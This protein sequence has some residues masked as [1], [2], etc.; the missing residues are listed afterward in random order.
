MN[1]RTGLEITH[2]QLAALLESHAQWL[3]GEPGGSRLD[4]VGANLPNANF[5]SANLAEADLRDAN[6]ANANFSNAYLAG[7]R[8]GGANLAGVDLTGYLANASLVGACLAD[9]NLVNVNLVEANLMYADLAGADLENA[10]LTNASIWCAYLADANLTGANLAGA[11]LGGAILAGTNL[12]GATSANVEGALGLNIT[13][14]AP[15]RRVKTQAER[16]AQFR[17]RNPEVPFVENLDRKILEAIE[18]PAAFGT[19][20]VPDWHNSETARTRAGWAIYLAGAAGN[21][22]E[23]RHGREIAAAMIYRASTGRVPY[24][25]GGNVGTIEAIRRLVVADW[26]RLERGQ[27]EQH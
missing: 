11:T 1:E 13:A 15:H 6:F 7:T 10:D 14:L 12:D 16:I 2:E 25:L 23:R 21:A 24:P 5:T 27:D 8:L 20:E 19:L 17:A 26:Q 18:G 3:R 22:L 4:L 9:A